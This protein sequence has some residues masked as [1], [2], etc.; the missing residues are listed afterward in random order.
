VSSNTSSSREVLADAALF[1][2]PYRV[3]DMS[4]KAIHMLEDEDLMITLLQKGLERARLFTPEK[5]TGE[6]L[7]V[8]ESVYGN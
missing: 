8:F 5:M 1:F 6:L 7:S 4:L 3:E 2:N